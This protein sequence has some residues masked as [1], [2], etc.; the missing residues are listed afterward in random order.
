MTTLFGRGTEKISLLPI[1]SIFSG[2]DDTVESKYRSCRFA[3][4]EPNSRKTTAS[5][6]LR[7]HDL[8]ATG[9]EEVGAF[10]DFVCRKPNN[11]VG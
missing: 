7:P 11:F 8:S 5:R 6:Q 4:I 2:S 9:D 1:A 10:N 3:E